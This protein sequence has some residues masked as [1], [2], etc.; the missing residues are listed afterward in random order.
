MRRDRLGRLCYTPAMTETEPKDCVFVA[1]DTA[2][3]ARAARLASALRGTVGGVKVG[4]ELFTAHGPDGVRA[5]A[6]GERLFLDL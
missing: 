3:L 1:L 5:V 6:G 2:D 4:K